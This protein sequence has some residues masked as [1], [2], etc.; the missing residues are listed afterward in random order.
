MSLFSDFTKA[1]LEHP[2]HL[3]IQ[4]SSLWQNL[5]WNP[6]V[7]PMKPHHALVV[8]H[9]SPP[10]S[11]TGTPQCALLLT[12]LHPGYFFFPGIK[13][14]ICFAKSIWKATQFLLKVFLFTPEDL[15]FSLTSYSMLTIIPFSLLYMD[16]IFSVTSFKSYLTSRWLEPEGIGL[17]L[18]SEFNK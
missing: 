6:G 18:S 8:H 1:N 15:P 4:N 10:F 14:P 7:S 11:S 2:T 17:E 3:P 12:C 16:V 5:P 13:N 9:W